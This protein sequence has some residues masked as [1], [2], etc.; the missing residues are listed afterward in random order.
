MSNSA[1]TQMGQKLKE[2]R[3]YLGYSQDDVAKYLAIARSAVSLIENGKRK[4]DS[5]ELQKLSELFETPIDL[6]TGTATTHQGEN[7]TVLQ[8]AVNSL[9]SED[10]EEVLRFAEYLKQRS[11][12]RGNHDK[13]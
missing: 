11:S 7:F 5:V 6:L 9:S 13:A 8:R 3:E 1:K 10:K 4:I 12:Q 2:I